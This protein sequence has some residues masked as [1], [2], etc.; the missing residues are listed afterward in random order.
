MNE[1]AEL[2]RENVKAF[3]KQYLVDR[4]TTIEREGI[5]GDTL[6]GILNQGFIGSNL[7]ESKGGAGLDRLSHSVLIF[8]LASVSPS[9][10]MHVLML[11]DVVLPL[12]HEKPEMIHAILSG[13]SVGIYLNPMMDGYIKPEGETTL[14]GVLGSS[15]TYV[16]AVHSDGKAYIDFGKSEKQNGSK[17]LGMRGLG[18][19]NFNVEKS[20][21]IGDRKI[22]EHQLLTS[23]LDIASMFLGIS[24]GALDKAMEYTKVRKTF[25]HPL[26]DYEPVSFRLTELV[27]E[28]EIMK[29]VLFS[30]YV[31]EIMMLM[32]KNQAA[33]FSRKA[34]RYAL[35][36]HGGYGY[37]E[38]FGVEKFY[39]DSVALNAM[40]YR[41]TVDKS[42]LAT[43][44]YSDK[45]GFL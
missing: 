16:I 9:V 15:P 12:L 45:S 36:F 19:C 34:T 30:D 1:Q 24:Q 38:D 6:Q 23:S 21:M 22:V 14:E 39:R 3:T 20:E 26:K 28:L 40:I 8:E 37:L 33:S 2:M 18:T 32:L 41:P 35:Q 10:A 25:G 13:E 31:E 43:K 44:L 42:F 5:D 17:P 27:S 29:N 11:N 4:A 7:P